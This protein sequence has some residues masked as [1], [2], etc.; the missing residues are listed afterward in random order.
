MSHSSKPVALVIGASRGIGRQVAIDL[1]KNGYRVIV[2]AKTTSNASECNPFPPDPNSFKSTIST[3]AREITEIYGGEAEAIPCDVRFYEQ[4]QELVKKGVSKFGGRLDVVVYNSGAIWWSSVE[5]TDFKRFQLMQRINPEGLYGT[6][7]AALPYLY[8]STDGGKGRGRIVVVSPPIYSRF[9]KGKAAYAMVCL[10]G[11]FM[12][13]FLVLMSFVQG[14]FG[15]SA[16]TMGLAVDWEREGR[17]GLAI[18]SLWP[19]VAIESAATQNARSYPPQEGRKQL[20]KPEIFSD[21]ILAIINAPAKDVNGKTLLDEDFLRE[22]EGVTDFSK[23]ALVP[24]T[25]PRRIMPM[26]MPDLSVAE[27]DDEGVRKD[28]AAERTNKL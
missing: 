17:T 23:Y 5:G 13:D 20:R 26:K 18:A 21:A 27:Q 15:M 25:T 14:K 19:A 9:V 12:R 7:Q 10:F 28:S 1:A 2:S 3:V 24:G 6:V 8:K 16:L 4:I 11:V 22:H